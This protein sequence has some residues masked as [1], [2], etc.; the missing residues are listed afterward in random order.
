MYCLNS[1]CSLPRRSMFCLTKLRTLTKI[2]KG[3]YVLS[4]LSVFS[5][6]TFYVLSHQVAYSDQDF[7]RSPCIFSLHC[8]LCARRSTFC[9]TMVSHFEPGTNYKRWTNKVGSAL[10]PEPYGFLFTL[11]CSIALHRIINDRIEN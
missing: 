6:K 11:Y 1:V 5:T 9:L 4:Q 7:Q 8:V 3:L 2:F 10:F